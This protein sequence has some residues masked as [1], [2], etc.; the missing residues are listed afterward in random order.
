MLVI[1]WNKTHCQW[2]IV[3]T[4]IGK[5]NCYT[6][7]IFPIRSSPVTDC[8]RKFWFTIL[9]NIF[10]NSLRFFKYSQ[11]I[12][13]HL[14]FKRHFYIGIQRFKQFLCFFI[15][16]TVQRKIFIS[17]LCCKSSVPIFWS[18]WFLKK[19][20]TVI[21]FYPDIIYLGFEKLWN[22]YYSTNTLI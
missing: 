22:N 4:F 2:V 12:V 14:I 18:L 15:V 21:Y 6:E 17:H 20:D 9:Q 5:M 11:Y 7:K 13:S 3:P 10:Q 1:R 16:E 19:K 8:G